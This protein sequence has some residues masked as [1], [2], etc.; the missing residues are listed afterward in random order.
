MAKYFREHETVEKLYFG[1]CNR[2]SI[3]LF[4]QTQKLCFVLKHTRIVKHATVCR[5]SPVNNLLSGLTL[6]KEHLMPTEMPQDL[7]NVQNHDQS[8]PGMFTRHSM[9]VYRPPGYR[10]ESSLTVL[11]GEQADAG[12]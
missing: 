3:G 7:S 4:A 12:T 2:H 10:K 1:G 5:I 9:T 6:D 8:R 11:P